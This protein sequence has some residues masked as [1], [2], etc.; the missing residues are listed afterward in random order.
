MTIDTLLPIKQACPE[1]I[2]SGNVADR[3]EHA[4][5]KLFAE[6]LEEILAT[7]P[8]L[9]DTYTLQ[10]AQRTQWKINEPGLQDQVRYLED[11][12]IKPEL[13]CPTFQGTRNVQRWLI[14]TGVLRMKLYFVNAHIGKDFIPVTLGEPISAE[15]TLKAIAMLPPGSTQ[16][17]PLRTQL[18][19][20]RN[21]RT[22][23]GHRL[24]PRRIDDAV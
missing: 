2:I 18:A 12:G 16:G 1:I 23:A 11:R 21:D 8:D 13:Q 5:R 4:D 9:F 6:P 19:A 15:M 14:D 7:E 20:D 22:Y 17:S 10:T 3:K 24:H